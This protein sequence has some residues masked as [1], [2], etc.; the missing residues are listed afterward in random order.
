MFHPPVLRRLLQI[1]PV[2][3]TK[4]GKDTKKQILNKTNV[5]ALGFI[6]ERKRDL[7]SLHYARVDD[8]IRIIMRLGRGTRLADVDIGGALRLCPVLLEDWQLL[9]IHWRQQYYYDIVFPFGLLS[10]PYIFDQVVKT[11]LWICKV[12]FSV[13]DLLHPLDGCLTAGP[14]KLPLCQQRPDIILA[15]CKPFG[16]PVASE[17]TVWPRTCLQ[18]LGIQLEICR[19]VRSTFTR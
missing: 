6:R 3:I 4:D 10:V 15:T 2:F 5:S 7:Y 9:G 19:K 14:P 18:I 8:A 16:I 12:S 11:L 17:K 1:V 13:T